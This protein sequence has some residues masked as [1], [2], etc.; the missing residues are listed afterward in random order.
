[1]MMMAGGGRGGQLGGMDLSSLL[2]GH[3]GGGGAAAGFGHNQVCST[4]YTVH[5]FGWR[6]SSTTVLQLTLP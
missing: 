5:T 3:L 6:A 2:A 4:F 1:M